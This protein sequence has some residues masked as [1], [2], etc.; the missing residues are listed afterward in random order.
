MKFF[1][2]GEIKLLWPFYLETFISTLFIIYSAF[3]IIQLQETLTLTQIGFLIT[4]LSLSS[5]IFEIPTG[6]IADVFGRKFSVIL[7]YFMQGLSIVL[8]S[9]L[10]NFYGL[11]ISFFLW[12][13]FGTFVSGAHEAW[14]TDNLIYKK[15]KDLIDNY[16][17]KDH[18]FTKISV[19]LSGFI[20]TL[21]VNQ[22][23]INI[24]WPVT[25]VS[26]FLSG[27]ILFFVPEHKVTKEKKKSV[28][29]LISYSKESMKY[30]LKNK[31]LLYLFIALFFVSFF[32]ILRSN[33]AWQPFLKEIGLPVYTFGILF[34]CIAFFGAIAPYL[35]KPIIR[36]IGKVNVFLALVLLAQIIIAFLVLFVNSWIIGVI[37]MTSLFF[38]FDLYNPIRRS[39]F[40]KFIPSKMRATLGS[41]GPTI[42]AF[43]YILSGPLAGYLVD[44]FGPKI[45]IA[46]SGLFLIPATIL[47]LKIKEK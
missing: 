43:A 35:A 23:G 40:Q 18:S 34:S 5:F 6:V 27:L 10:N 1:K 44:T 19:V 24:I 2:Q 8:I 21:L 33:I 3:Y 4:A 20:G 39:Y 36:K 12:G 28:T 37:L 16:F 32:T 46:L 9:I 30:S 29:E 42:I 17:I 22:L 7:G 31:T 14:A 47:Y 38:V 26:F 11:L 41:F 15:R 13:I 45:T 25:S